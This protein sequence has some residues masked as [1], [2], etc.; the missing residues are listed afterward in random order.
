[1]Q[2][3]LLVGCWAQSHAGKLKKVTSKRYSSSLGKMY[4]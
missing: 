1:M 2:Q 3:A 4:N